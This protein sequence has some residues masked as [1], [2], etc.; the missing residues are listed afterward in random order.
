M[1]RPDDETR[2]SD[3]IVGTRCG[4]GRSGRGRRT[5]VTFSLT[6][7]QEAI[8]RLFA[9][10]RDLAGNLPPLPAIF[11]DMPAPAVRRGSDGER[12]LVMMRW[13]FAPPPNLGKV[14]VTNVRNVTSP[15]WRGWLKPEWRALIPATSFCE[16]RTAGRK[17]R[18]GSRSRN[19]GRLSPLCLCG[20]LAAWSG[21]RKGE[22][23]EHKLFS[24]LTTEAND[25]VRPIHAK[26]M[27]VLLTTPEEWDVW[28]A[29]TVDESKALQR[30]LPNDVL[31][32]VAV[33][34]KS[35]GA[36]PAD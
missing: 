22:G 3:N 10:R 9:I 14:P 7:N 36:T 18:I 25:V 12:E 29:G 16:W 8:R 19:C 15:Y 4:K 21:E 20:N 24:F 2:R 30:P 13:G 33:G 11:P 17:S 26:A 28:L 5:C 34:A 6:R 27:P 1:A 23:G 35:D 32:I 31:K